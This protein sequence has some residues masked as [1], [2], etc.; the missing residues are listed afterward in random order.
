[1]LVLQ[2]CLSYI[3]ALFLQFLIL[4]FCTLQVLLGYTQLKPVSYLSTETLALL[5]VILDSSTLQ[6]KTV[7]IPHM[8]RSPLCADPFP[9]RMRSQCPSVPQQ[10][11]L[12]HQK[13]C[14]AKVSTTVSFVFCFC[15]RGQKDFPVVH[16]NFL[17]HNSVLYWHCP[18]ECYVI[19][20]SIVIKFYQMSS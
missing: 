6:P 3:F 9:N 20:C 18:V 2:P 14:T 11:N 19:L 12:H 13:Y 5:V 7:P 4:I 17:L 16:V 15:S 10:Q 1:M 8:R